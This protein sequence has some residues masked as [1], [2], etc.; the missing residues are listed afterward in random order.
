M[1]RIVFDLDGTLIDSAPDIR[2]VANTVL[3]RDGLSP[4]SL[5]QTRDF[6]GNGVGLFV[7]RMRIARGIPDSEHDRI[8]AEFIRLYEDAVTLTRVY[9]QVER[10]L[11]MLLDAGHVLGICTNKPVRPCRAVLAHLGLDRF[12]QT[13]WGGDSL[14]VRKPNPAP[15]V[16]AFDALPAAQDIFVG[17]SEIDAETA[18][19]AGVPFLLFSEGY[20]KRPVAEIPHHA[21]FADFAELPLLVDRLTADHPTL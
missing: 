18:T 15:L 10:T 7:E 13:V 11:Q 16:A 5:G 12:F 4:I 3:E 8:L 17:D 21:V 20:R 1:A 14:S 2:G 6:A 19:R 9:P